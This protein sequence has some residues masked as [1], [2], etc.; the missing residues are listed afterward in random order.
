V[1]YASAHEDSE[2]VI[3]GAPPHVSVSIAVYVIPSRSEESPEH[4]PHTAHH[5]ASNTN[6]APTK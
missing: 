5:L 6:H 2:N 1:W 4:H 3:A